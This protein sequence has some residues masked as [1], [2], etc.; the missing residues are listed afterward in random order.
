MEYSRELDKSSVYHFFFFYDNNRFQCQ[1]P[2]YASK[3][4]SM[5][6]G[7]MYSRV[8]RVAFMAPSYAP[9]PHSFILKAND[10]LPADRP[11]D[12]LAMKTDVAPL[13]PPSRVRGGG[14]DDGGLFVWLLVGSGRRGKLT[15][16]DCL[17]AVATATTPSLGLSSLN[18]VWR[19]VCDCSTLVGQ[20]ACTL[21]DHREPCPTEFSQV[22]ERGTHAREQ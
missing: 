17:L 8:H 12:R 9:R 15:F 13:P 22:D 6:A 21:H 7:S 14:D 1:W 4:A 19:C 10:S 20:N 18:Q 16:T 5:H 2:V 3:Q 11:T